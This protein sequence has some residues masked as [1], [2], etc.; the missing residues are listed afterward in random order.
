MQEINL[1]DLL[2]H[3]TRYWALILALSV[4]GFISG[5]VYN[6]YIQVP[7]YK[8]DATLI[9]ISNDQ[10]VAST[11]ATT[12]LINNYLELIKSR[13]VLEPVIRNNKL[14]LSYSQLSSDISTSS[15][16][17]TAVLKLSISSTSPQVSKIATNATIASFRAQVKSLYNKD[18]VQV[19]DSA[20][21]PTTPYNV[22]KGLQLMLFTAAGF[23]AA[24]IIV[25]FIYDYHLNRPQAK[26]ITASLKGKQIIEQAVVRDP[27]TGKFAPAK[28]KSAEAKKPAKKK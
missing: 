13:R 28:K 8:S 12:T 23:L 15:D 17:D 24:I 19:V 22:H 7:L 1:Y 27:K 11:T 3:Y 21:T 26:K 5:I 10:T 6:N 14:S 4:V 2:R 9:L 18:N 20:S 25:F 16:K